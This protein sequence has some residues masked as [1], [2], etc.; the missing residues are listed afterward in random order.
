[1]VPGRMAADAEPTAACTP[2]TGSQ[3]GADVT[4]V[5]SRVAAA[6][7]L[8]LATAVIAGGFGPRHM[9]ADSLAQVDMADWVIADQCAPVIDWL[10]DVVWPLRVGPGTVLTAQVAALLAGTYLVLRSIFVRVGSTA[11][12]C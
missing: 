8:T 3:Q 2:G 5:A 11:A 9:S 12:R 4:D 7:V 1:M 10:W 6:G